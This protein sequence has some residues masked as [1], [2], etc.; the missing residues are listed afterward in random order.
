MDQ[1]RP[2]FI[3]FRLFLNTIEIKVEDLAIY[4]TSI[5]GVRGSQT[6]TAGLK[7]ETNQLNYDGPMFKCLI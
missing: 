3:Y 6:Q 5:D 4:G 1:A 7:V 2:H